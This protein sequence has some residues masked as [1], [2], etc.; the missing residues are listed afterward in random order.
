MGC[1]NS[2]VIDAPADR[3][4]ARLRDF[5]DMSWAA[6]LI[7]RCEAV[8]HAA[9][10][11]IG[12]KRLVNG[13]CHETLLGLDDEGRVIRYRIDDSP[14]VVSKDNVQGYIGEVRVFPVTDTNRGFVLWTATWQTSGGGVAEFCD[15]I[16]QTLLEVL[17]KSFA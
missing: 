10:T 11:Q 4:W 2:T 8:G 1:C 17:K 13:V 6:G 14:G 16:Y 3:V 9:G 7:E 15:P 12:A 5:H